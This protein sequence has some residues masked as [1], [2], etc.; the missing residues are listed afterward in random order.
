MILTPTTCTAPIPGKPDKFVVDNTN[1]IKKHDRDWEEIGEGGG[2][3]EEDHED[4]EDGDKY[5]I[6]PAERVKSLSKKDTAPRGKKDEIKDF[7]VWDEATSRQLGILGFEIQLR[8]NYPIIPEYLD[9]RVEM[10]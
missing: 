3:E 6:S 8:G 5:S 9:L 4:G 10:W 2:E 7:D 1:D